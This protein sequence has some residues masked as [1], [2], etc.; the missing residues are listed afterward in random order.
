MPKLAEVVSSQIERDIQEDGWRVGSTF[1]SEPDLLRRYGVSRA[2]LR[3]AIRLLEHHGVAEMRRGL[4]GGLIVTEPTSDAVA[5]AMATCF[6][7]ERVRLHQLMDVCMALEIF[8]AHSVAE[9]MD[10]EKIARIRQHLAVETDGHDGSVDFAQRF[11][12]LIADLTGNPV[13]GVSVR[14]LTTLAR[15]QASF[16]PESAD[17][18]EVHLAHTHIADAIISGDSDVAQQTMRQHLEDLS[19]MVPKDD[20]FESPRLHAREDRPRRGGNPGNRSPRST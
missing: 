3:E 15:S 17:L 13:L 10:E 1:G 19:S 2:V 7:F 16:R 4:G 9:A 20:W 18:H 11:H 5:R 12:I 6:Q 8:A 14:S